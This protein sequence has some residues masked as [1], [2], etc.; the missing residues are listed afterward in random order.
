MPATARA[1]PVSGVA[2]AVSTW[3]GVVCGDAAPGL[4][5]WLLVVL[6]QA[7]AVP[8]PFTASEWFVPPAIA[9]TPESGLPQPLLSHTCTGSFC[10]V[11]VLPMP[12][13]PLPLLPQAKT[14]PSLFS[15]SECVSPAAIA[16]IPESLLAHPVDAHTWTGVDAVSDVV[17]S[18]RWPL[19]PAP[20]A[21]TLPSFFSASEC[22]S[23]AATCTTPM[24]VTQLPPEPDA[25][26][27][28]APHCEVVVPSPRRPNVLS[29]HAH[30][31]VSGRVASE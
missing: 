2:T 28:T 26:I 29:P 31:V 19:S 5:S 11:V 18:P 22:C 14:V 23:P 1:T 16:M 24:I 15:A 13:R 17:S 25:Q 30:A 27:V 7:H 21:Y 4:P 9:T 20:H 12:S 8:S 3:I 6:P 10:G